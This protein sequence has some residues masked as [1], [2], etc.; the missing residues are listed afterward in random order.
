MP[1]EDSDQ[2]RFKRAVERAEQA[3]RERI[4]KL[5][6]R[7]PFGIR[8]LAFGLDEQKIDRQRAALEYFG[9]ILFFL[10]DEYS[11]EPSSDDQLLRKVN[12]ALVG[13]R[14][15][16]LESKWPTSMPWET[17]AERQFDRALIPWLE[18]R[19]EW[20]EY[21]SR[22]LPQIRIS[23]E[24]A[25]P[26][27]SHR[28]PLFYCETWPFEGLSNGARKR[29][30][31]RL[32]ETHGDF[33]DDAKGQRTPYWI[34]AYDLIAGEFAADGLL[35]EDA[36]ERQIPAIAADAGAGGGWLEEGWAQARPSGVF[37]ERLGSQFYA[38]WRRAEFLK[39]LEGERNRWHGRM[40]LKPAGNVDGVPRRGRRPQTDAHNQVAKMVAD[41]GPDWKGETN[42][43]RL[44]EWMDSRPIALDKRVRDQRFEG[45][46]EY[47]ELEP[48]KFV[49][50]IEYRLTRAKI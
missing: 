6:P 17:E 12:V 1:A 10:I 9:A 40:L 25:H 20:R 41:L 37:S 26:E 19:A 36:A 35:T 29:I 8:P 33:L 28:T 47:L 32:L 49:K 24:P 11:S 21:E 3:Y 39:A 22:V 30:Q 2:D 46:R 13:L 50:A 42:L 15:I 27:P 16:T 43:K 34:R 44:A 5:T 45:W 18:G 38:P 7:D 31:A 14:Q 4:R 48:E 23:N